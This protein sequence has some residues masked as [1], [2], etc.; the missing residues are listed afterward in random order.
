MN[1]T[2]MPSM[3]TDGWV[4]DSV[5]IVDYMMSHFF[6][7]EFS[8]TA[9][10]PGTISS[11]QYLIEK[12]QGSPSRTA[13]AIKETLTLYF[14]RYFKEVTVQTQHRPDATDDTRASIDIFIEY[15][16]DDNVKMSFGKSA[17]IVNGKYSK[18]VNINNNLGEG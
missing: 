8:Q 11:I 6:L 3:S 18:I 15:T 17:D 2:P 12:N 13:Q 9:L 14:E 7:A 1:L 16:D 4:Y 5:H 10:Y